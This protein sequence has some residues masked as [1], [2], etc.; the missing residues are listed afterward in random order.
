MGRPAASSVQTARGSSCPACARAT[1][2]QVLG[3]LYA[4]MKDQPAPVDLDALWE[5]LG[6]RVEGGATRL[7]D[8]APLAAT[9]QAITAPHSAPLHRGGQP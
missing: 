2:V 8:T 1:G 3:A 5:A 4:R 7:D 6:V 9:R